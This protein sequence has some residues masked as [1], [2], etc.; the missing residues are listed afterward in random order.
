M[1]DVA[2]VQEG[3]ASRHLAQRAQHRR[4][5]GRRRQRALLAH[6]PAV[7]CTVKGLEQAW[8]EGIEM[9]VRKEEGVREASRGRSGR[10]AAR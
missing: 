4:H 3:H 1:H 2:R 7:N 8:E 10:V 6:P 9:R 5:R